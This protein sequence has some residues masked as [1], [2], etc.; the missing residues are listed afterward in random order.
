[1]PTLCDAS[2]GPPPAMRAAVVRFS[3]PTRADAFPSPF[4]ALAFPVAVRR[5]FLVEQLVCVRDDLSVR[6]RCG[7]R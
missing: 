2:R 7:A 3:S 5:Y 4:E 1:M 6:L